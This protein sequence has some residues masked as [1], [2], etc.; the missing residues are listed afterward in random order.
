LHKGLKGESPACPFFTAGRNFDNYW[1]E[2]EPDPLN[3]TKLFAK[4]SLR[5]VPKKIKINFIL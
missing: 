4:W 3:V 5:D 2:R 1:K